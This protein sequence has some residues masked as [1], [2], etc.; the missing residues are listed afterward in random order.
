MISDR[1]TRGGN[2]S[3]KSGLLLHMP[4]DQK[5]RG[6][7]IVLGENL[8]QSRRTARVRSIVISKCE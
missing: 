6:L 4:S 3:R 2:L 7:H 1:V 8:K 5:E